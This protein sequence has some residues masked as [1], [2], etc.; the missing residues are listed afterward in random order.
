M[1]LCVL[2]HWVVFVFIFWDDFS[3]FYLSFI[4]VVVREGSRFLIQR[5]IWNRSSEARIRSK[6]TSRMRKGQDWPTANLWRPRVSHVCHMWR[7]PL[8]P[9]VP[10]VDHTWKVMCPFLIGH[11][12]PSLLHLFSLHLFSLHI[13][14]KSRAEFSTTFDFLFWSYLS[15]INSELSD[16]KTKI[17]GLEERNKPQAISESIEVVIFLSKLIAVRVSSFVG[18]FD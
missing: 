16:S 13:Y 10:H 5:Q 6:N 2:I 12:I 1:L 18:L 4:V 7:T 15:P 17:V 3:T 14:S 8:C 11:R 9:H